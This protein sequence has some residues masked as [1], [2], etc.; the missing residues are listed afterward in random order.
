MERLHLTPASSKYRLRLSHPSSKVGMKSLVKGLK[1]YPLSFK[2]SPRH[3][4][5]SSNEPPDDQQL[6]EVREEIR[7]LEV[8]YENLTGHRWSRSADSPNSA[9]H[10]SSKVRKFDRQ[11]RAL[12]SILSPIR[13]IPNEVLQEI[14][15][16]AATINRASPVLGLPV[17]QTTLGE[18]R[19]LALVCRRWK[20]AIVAAHVLWQHVPLHI[21]LNSQNTTP[22][23]ERDSQM[24]AIQT[25]LKRAGFLPVCLDIHQFLNYGSLLDRKQRFNEHTWKLLVDNTARW[26]K[27]SLHAPYGLYELLQE[28]TDGGK[29]FEQLTDLTIT[30]RPSWNA[31]GQGGPLSI[32]AFVE[33]PKLRNVSLV[34]RWMAYISEDTPKVTIA[35]PWHQ[36]ERYS[37][38]GGGDNALDCILQAN[39]QDL[40]YLNYVVANFYTVPPKHPSTMQKLQVLRAQAGRNASQLAALIDQLVLPSLVELQLRGLFRPEDILFTK[41]KNLV[42]RSGC[43]LS[44]LELDDSD[45]DIATFTQLLSLTPTLEHLD[46]TRP[47]DAMLRALVL[48]PSSADPILPKLSSLTIELS[49]QNRDFEEE[50]RDYTCDIQVLRAVLESRMHAIIPPPG[51]FH[52]ADYFKTLGEFR[53]GCRIH[54]A[55][56]TCVWDF[57][58]M[59]EGPLTV[60]NFPDERLQEWQTWFNTQLKLYSFGKD[61]SKPK[62]YFALHQFLRELENV[63]LN[64]EILQLLTVSVHFPSFRM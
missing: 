38:H 4:L 55:N 6:L 15:F 58:E 2:T 45:T 64:S 5:L 52:N 14:L 56:L 30:L 33:A 59:L 47:L 42:A 26:G 9:K 29:R 25:H 28:N 43:S 31:T 48:D 19:R 53:L 18:A 39:P 51:S 37:S 35:L 24:K 46:I 1:T 11:I 22:A 17:V 27:V 16:L 20:R 57:Q 54:Y 32:D 44:K 10:L 12:H 36:L 21:C 3:A 62:L 41:V 23:K 40:V 50:Q 8:K 49:E 7:K 34:A 61:L 63:K 13:R 60:P